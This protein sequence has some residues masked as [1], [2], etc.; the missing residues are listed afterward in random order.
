M[1]ILERPLYS[2]TASGELASTLAFKKGDRWPRLEVKRVAARS[3]TAG[4]AAQR[5]LFYGKKNAWHALTEPEKESYRNGAP[6]GWTGY[7]YFLFIALREAGAYLGDLVLGADLVNQG[8]LTGPLSSEDYQLL[9]PP[10]T[11]EVPEYTDGVDPVKDWMLNKLTDSTLAVE[12]Y[13]ILYHETI[14]RG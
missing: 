6:S 11:D 13:L 2:D 1:P 8:N 7:S 12:N 9:F 3:R 4:Q 14:E 10:A 5:D